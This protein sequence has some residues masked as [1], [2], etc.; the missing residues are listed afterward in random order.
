MTTWIQEDAGFGAKDEAKT[1]LHKPPTIE[2]DGSPKAIIVG[3]IAF[4]GLMGVIDYLQGHS[5]NG[6]CVETDF[7]VCC[8]G[9]P[10]PLIIQ[11]NQN[12]K[13]ATKTFSPAEIKLLKKK[14]VENKESTWSIFQGLDEMTRSCAFEWSSGKSI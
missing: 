4:C 11:D 2:V 3:V 7:N 9:K 13:F 1:E 10:H 5:A 6:L 12:A 8:R 14:N